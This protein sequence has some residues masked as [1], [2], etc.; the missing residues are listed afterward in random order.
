MTPRLNFPYRYLSTKQVLPTDWDP[1][2][3][4]FTSIRLAAIE[5]MNQA[6]LRGSKRTIKQLAST[7]QG[8]DHHEQITNNNKQR[9]NNHSPYL[10]EVLVQTLCCCL[11]CFCLLWCA[12]RAPCVRPWGLTQG[13]KQY[14]RNT[15]SNR[16][17][18][19]LEMNLGVA[20]VGGL[21]C[22]LTR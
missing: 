1:K 11:A 19:T 16:A 15:A 4:T 20:R 9:V 14:T 7:S 3:T 5:M 10:S 8:D 22:V 2:S 6:T 17:V 13:R 21:L 18:S 12:V